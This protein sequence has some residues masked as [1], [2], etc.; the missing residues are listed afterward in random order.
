M[1]RAVSRRDIDGATRLKA[2]VLPA[3]QFQGDRETWTL[4][5]LA[6]AVVGRIFKA[7]AAPVGSPP[8]YRLI[9]L[10][11][12]Q[13]SLAS[14]SVGSAFPLGTAMDHMIKIELTPSEVTALKELAAAGP[15]GRKS[16]AVRR[17]LAR[18][19]RAHYVT[20]QSA[21][22]DTVVYVITDHGRRALAN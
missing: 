14:S 15:R 18:L 6:G 2:P 8:A 11:L 21:S 5:H 10:P 9:I 20:E 13:P 19:I 16:R 22:M 3:P 1:V 12:A 4:G 7:N 17:D